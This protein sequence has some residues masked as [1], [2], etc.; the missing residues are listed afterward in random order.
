MFV[1]LRDINTPKNTLLFDY[2]KQINCQ[3]KRYGIL[4]WI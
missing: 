2:S 3:L 4:F 1:E